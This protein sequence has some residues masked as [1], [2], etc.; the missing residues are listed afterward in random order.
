MTTENRIFPFASRKPGTP[1]G[2][3]IKAQKDRAEIVLYGV[4]GPSWFEDGISAAQFQKD[5]KALGDVKN[6]D[7]RIN[8]DGGDVFDGQA[9]YT[10]LAQHKAEVTAYIDGLAASAASFIAMA[11]DKIVMSEGAWMMIHNAW[12]VAV[13]GANDLRDA[14]NLLDRINVTMVE[15]Y[16]ARTGNDQKE[17]KKWMDA[18]TWMEA[19]E[20][21]EKGFA[22]EVVGN[23]KMAASVSRPKIYSTF[24]NIPNALLPNRAAAA[25]ALSS[26]K[27]LIQKHQK[28][29][30]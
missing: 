15:K 16:A 22:E 17:I 18:E 21:K 14:G 1:A 26:M 27:A 7:L 10:L 2:Y 6:I 12:G 20:A 19:K 11:A 3:R 28:N 5:L 30:V 25:A 23:V 8:S 9:I 29:S 24:K 13:G 4:I